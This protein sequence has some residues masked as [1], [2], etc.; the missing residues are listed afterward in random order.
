MAGAGILRVLDEAPPARADRSHPH[1]TVTDRFRRRLEPPRR[2][3]G[4]AAR[5]RACPQP[6]IV[7]VI[8]DD[9]GARL[10]TAWFLE[11]ENYRVLSFASGDAFLDAQLPEDLA[12]V[13]LDLRLPGRN[14]LEVLGVLGGRDDSPPVL[15]LTGHADVAIAVAAMKLKASD[16]IQKPYQPKLLLAAV[17]R[18]SA[19][20]E[21]A[22]SE[23]A[24]RRQARIA[25]EGLSERQRQVLTGIA[26]GRANKLIAWDL[27]LSIR[28]VEAYRAQL[29]QKLG[30]RNT[31]QGVRIAVAAGLLGQPTFPSRQ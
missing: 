26:A 15:L 19:Q 14:G 7:A 21:R 1:R 27:G 8:D 22:L 6:P 5:E 25:I 13:L 11:G 2:T 3:A 29:L 28:T 31:A 9:E 23:G 16:V 17:E 24:A 18:A 4:P 30:A 20:R 10:S 12:C